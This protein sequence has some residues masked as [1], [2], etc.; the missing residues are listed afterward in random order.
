VSDLRKKLIRWDRGRNAAIA[1]WE[2][3]NTAWKVDLIGLVVLGLSCEIIV[4]I[5]DMLG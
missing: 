5:L 1:A 2:G 3:R 4:E